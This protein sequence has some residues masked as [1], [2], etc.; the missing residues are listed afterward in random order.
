MFN[1]K[2]ILFIGKKKKKKTLL[3]QIDHGSTILVVDMPR[4]SFNLWPSHEE[5][6]LSATFSVWHVIKNFKFSWPVD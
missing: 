1:C 3:V 2:V 5:Y 4:F 6:C